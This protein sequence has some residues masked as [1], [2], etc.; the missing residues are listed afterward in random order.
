[1]AV[2]GTFTR[3]KDGGWGGTI[4]T[5]SVTVKARFV[6]NDN[7][8]GV[9]S[10]DYRVLCGTSELGAAWT[11]RGSTAEHREYL[12]VQLDDPSLP[13]PIAA[14]LFINEDSQIANLVWNR[15]HRVCEDKQEE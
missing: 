8:E 9:S 6:P 11:R 13:N 5:L 4:R 7:R 14:A 1:V 15:R 10:P 2:I 3:A 12:S